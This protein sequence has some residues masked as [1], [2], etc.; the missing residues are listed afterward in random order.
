MK[1]LTNKNL[2]VVTVLGSLMAPTMG[3]AC[4]C[5]CGVF[6]VG[7]GAMFLNEPGGMAYVNYDYQDQN[8]NWSGTSQVSPDLNPDKEIKTD[9]INL[10]FEY[11]F[12]RSWGVSAELPYD[13]RSFKTTSAAPGSPITEIN[14]AAL[15]DLRVHAFYTGF[16]PDLSSG[17]DL[18]LKLPTGDF[19][20]ENYWGDIDRD[21]QIGTGSTDLLVGGYY[22]GNLTRNAKW[23]WFAQTELDVPLLTQDDYRP[24]VEVDTAAGIDYKG[25]SWG[26]MRVS[27]VGQVIFSD[28][29]SDSGA[30]AANP[31]ASGYQRLMLSPGVEFHLHPVKIY[32]DVELPVWQDFTGNQLAASI[33][34][35]VNISF[36]F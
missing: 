21:S 20:H 28:R 27:P 5:G 29:L 1:I 11:L 24:G 35:K 3:W 22:R 19:T 13:Y 33:L 23:D 12:N 36:H 30:N 14:W 32:V 10:G 7:G 31:V 15:G 17:I 26:R 34:Y 25:F 16:S 4:A 2:T 9:Y 6:D 8:R 18:G